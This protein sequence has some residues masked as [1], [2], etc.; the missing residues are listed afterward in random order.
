MNSRG[1]ALLRCMSECSLIVLNGRSISDY[2]AQITHLNKLGKSV[3]DLVWCDA[4]LLEQIEDMYVEYGITKSDHFAVVVSLNHKIGQNNQIIEREGMMGNLKWKKHMCEVFAEEIQY[5]K[6]VAR[7]DLDIN[8]MYENLKETIKDV[9]KK[10]V[11]IPSNKFRNASKNKPWFDYECLNNKI[12]MKIKLRDCKNSAFESKEKVSEFLDS[13]KNYIEVIKTKKIDY[14]N[15]KLNSLN[16]VKDPCSFWK[17]LNDF[18][19]KKN[20]N[21]DSISLNT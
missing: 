6:N 15:S 12:C 11:L 16:E 14:L 17:L 3:I 13:K 21:V 8:L 2:P 7:I 10:L 5:S 20:F 4:S 9:S 19:F 1:K 18:N